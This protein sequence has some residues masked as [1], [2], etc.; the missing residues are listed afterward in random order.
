MRVPGDDV[1]VAIIYAH[2]LQQPG[3]ADRPPALRIDD[4]HQGAALAVVESQPLGVEARTFAANVASA[5]QVFAIEQ[6]DIAEHPAFP[7]DRVIVIVAPCRHRPRRLDHHGL[8][9]GKGKRSDRKARNDQWGEDLV[10]R[11]ATD[12]DALDVDRARSIHSALSA[13][14]DFVLVTTAPLQLSAAALIWTQAADRAIVVATR[15]QS[16]RDDVTYAVESLGLVGA[17]LAGTALAE[18]AD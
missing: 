5:E 16:R 12:H 10:R 11:N 13:Q 4:A 1:A 15:D 3:I 14:A 17:H 9:E 7:G 18:L 2:A 8:V 6:P